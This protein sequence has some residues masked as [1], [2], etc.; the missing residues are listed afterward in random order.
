MRIVRY[1]DSKGD[2]GYAAETTGGAYTRIAGDVFNGFQVTREPA[3]IERL[4][5]PIV[6]PAIWCIGLNYRRHAAESGMQVPQHPVLFAKGVNSIQ[7]PGGPI[8]V[9]QAAASEEVDYECELVVVIGKKCRNATR[10]QALDYVFGYTCGNDVTAR[11]WQFRLGGTQWCRGKSFDTFAPLGP[12]IVTRDAI[13]DPNALRIQTVLNQQ[14]VQDWNTS[15]MIFDVAAL[16]SFL[17]QST[18]LLPG[19]LI[20]TGTPHGIGMAQ[21][22]PRWLRPGDEVSIVIEKIGT[23]TNTVCNEA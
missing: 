5:A 7:D 18:T 11:D 12:C 2:V 21:T 22:P 13:P 6:P 3:Q 23:L 8:V 9:P 10:A 14:V 16:I 19:T 17:S 1:E 20:F 15:D 4:L